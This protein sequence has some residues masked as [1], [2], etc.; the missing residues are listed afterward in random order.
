MRNGDSRRDLKG[1]CP[2]STSHFQGVFGL[3]P[4]PLGPWSSRGF[5]VESDGEAAVAGQGELEVLPVE[6][7][8]G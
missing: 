6:L 2:E 3:T 4:P 5:N 1:R 8:F 7:V